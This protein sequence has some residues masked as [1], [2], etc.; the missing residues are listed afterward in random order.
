[1]S[2]H[3]RPHPL[4]VH[5]SIS[6]EN[7]LSKISDGIEPIMKHNKLC[8]IW[9]K[10]L[11]GVKQ[12]VFFTKFKMAEKLSRRSLWVI[13][14]FF[15]EQVQADLY[16]KFQV[17]PSLAEKTVGTKTQGGARETFSFTQI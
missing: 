14:V 12:K 3:I 10:R 11:G 15:L 4:D 17:N 1:V 5:W 13:P 2:L 6:S 9:S 16:A 7:N 8:M